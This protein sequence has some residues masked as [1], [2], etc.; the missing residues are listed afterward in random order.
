MDPQSKRF[1][2]LVT[3]AIVLIMSATTLAQSQGADAKPASNSGEPQSSTVLKATTRLVVVDVVATDGKGVPITGLTAKDF[4]LTENG[5][6]SSVEQM[7]FQLAM[8]G[9]RTIHRARK[10]RTVSEICFQ[11][12]RK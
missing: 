11:R 3:S 7:F 9:S 2:W 5:S 1:G 4:V 10:P 6:T 8:R 12:F